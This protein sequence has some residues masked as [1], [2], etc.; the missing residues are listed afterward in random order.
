MSAPRLVR[1]PDRAPVRLTL[2]HLPNLHQRLF[3]HA[4]FDDQ[5]DGHEVS[6]ANLAPAALNAF[7]DG[8]AEIAKR[9]SEECS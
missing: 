2:I 3:D 9:K 5:T 7:L 6:I 8:E 1:L 4:A